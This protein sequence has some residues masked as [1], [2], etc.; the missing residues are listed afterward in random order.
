MNQE[1]AEDVKCQFIHSSQALRQERWEV[2]HSQLSG[3]TPASIGWTQGWSCSAQPP[4]GFSR[5]AAPVPKAGHQ[6]LGSG[7]TLVGARQS[8]GLNPC[9]SGVLDPR[10]Q[11]GVK[12]RASCFPESSLRSFLC[13]ALKAK[14]PLYFFWN[15]GKGEILKFSY[16]QALKSKQQ[17]HRAG[18][19]SPCSLNNIPAGLGLPDSPPSPG[20]LL[21]WN[22]IPE[23]FKSSFSPSSSKMTLMEQCSGQGNWCSLCS[24]SLQ[25]WEGWIPVMEFPCF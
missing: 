24:L 5:I 19:T 9:F 16:L 14:V 11:P 25:L 23:A 22:K 18:K 7:M 8:S 6:Q 17:K 15:I 20:L 10:K 3:D 13:S 2:T 4:P 12:P 21:L 1:R